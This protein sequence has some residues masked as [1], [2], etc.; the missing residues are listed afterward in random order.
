MPNVNA[1]SVSTASDDGDGFSL[2]ATP[3]ET[4]F[5]AAF[6]RFVKGN[7]A[8]GAAREPVEHGTK[9]VAFG[10]KEDWLRLE[11]G[12]PVQ[13]IQREPN[14]PFPT[15]S[16]LGDLDQAAWPRFDGKPSDP[17]TLS[18]ELL[19]T[20][21]DTGRP[22]IFTTTSWTGRE[23]VTDLCRLITYQRRQRGANARPIITIGAGTYQSPRGPVA[24]PKFAIVD[25]VDGA[26]EPPQSQLDDDLMG[27]L[28]S[29][30]T[31]SGTAKSTSGAA[32]MRRQLRPTPVDDDLDD[33]IP[34]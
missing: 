1:L 14:K 26:Q 6:M 34:F 15:R 19:L 5:R 8:L 4:N 17:W 3:S 12:A 20:E 27:H 21:K 13:R 11:K 18:N 10:A 32:R 2:V 7:Y 16:E 29:R 23:A 25:W 31:I 9:F 28:Q 24:I 33:E 30:S 22:V